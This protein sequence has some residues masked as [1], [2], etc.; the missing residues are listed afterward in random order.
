P[1]RN[2]PRKKDEKQTR[3]HAGD[4]VGTQFALGLV[5]FG[6]REPVVNKQGGA[7]QQ[8]R[9]AGGNQC[10]E[11]RCNCDTPD[12]RAGIGCDT[13]DSCIAGDTTVCTVFCN[14]LDTNNGGQNWQDRKSVV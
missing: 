4:T 5:M 9:T 6:T 1:E 7:R 2:K 3:E 14:S 11:Y 10:C 12:N 13:S 8:D